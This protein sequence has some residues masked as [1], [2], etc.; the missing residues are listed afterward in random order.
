MWL[1]SDFAA[2]CL[3]LLQTLCPIPLGAEYHSNQSMHPIPAEVQAPACL[4]A[5]N[6]E[7]ALPLLLRHLRQLQPR[8]HELIV[9]DGGSQDRSVLSAVYDDE[10]CNLIMVKLQMNEGGRS[11]GKSVQLQVAARCFLEAAMCPYGTWIC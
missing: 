4:Q 2:C 10:S 11:T 6:E 1:L 3:T 7:T 8:A 9:V 5:L